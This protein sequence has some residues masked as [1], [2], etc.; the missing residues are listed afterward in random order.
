MIQS[1]TWWFMTHLIKSR[2]Q[3]VS[4]A[5]GEQNSRGEAE[6]VCK[7]IMHAHYTEEKTKTWAFSQ[8]Q[9]KCQAAE[10]KTRGS[11]KQNSFPKGQAKRIIS[12]NTCLRE[13]LHK[14]WLSNFRARLQRSYTETHES[15]T[16]HNTK[17]TNQKGATLLRSKN[18]NVSKW[19]LCIGYLSGQFSFT[20]EF[21]S[22]RIIAFFPSSPWAYG[23]G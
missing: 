21:P 2:Q 18:Q 11:C 20:P 1:R 13:T 14:K 17:A 3:Y 5:W 16:S 8:C 23:R 12:W 9:K 6:Y 15:H 7:L 22:Q 4:E 10:K 19:I